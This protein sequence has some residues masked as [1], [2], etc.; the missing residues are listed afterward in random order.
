MV[1]AVAAA[2]APPLPPEDALAAP[3]LLLLLLLL[4]V[5]LFALLAAGATGAAAAERD[6]IKG[7]LPGAARLGGRRPWIGFARLRYVTY[8]CQTRISEILLQ[9]NPD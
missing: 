9:R 3:M 2:Y 1:A 6:A 4:V 7:Q 5:L 8:L